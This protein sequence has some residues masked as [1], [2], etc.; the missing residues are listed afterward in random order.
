MIWSPVVAGAHNAVVDTV[1]CDGGRGGATRPEAQLT[2]NH[3]SNEVKPRQHKV[4]GH[5]PTDVS[6][7]GTQRGASSD[8]AH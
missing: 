8:V 2:M 1:I 6:K 7:P 3:M 4:K 5:R